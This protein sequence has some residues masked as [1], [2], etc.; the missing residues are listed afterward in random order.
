MMSKRIKLK[1]KN[2]QDSIIVNIHK[3]EILKSKQGMVLVTGHPMHVNTISPD[4][5]AEHYVILEPYYT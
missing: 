3:N 2:H 1:S 5:L 4:A